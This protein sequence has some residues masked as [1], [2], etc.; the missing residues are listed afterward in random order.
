[1]FSA[2]QTMPSSTSTI[3]TTRRTIGTR[4]SSSLLWVR[5]AILA[6]TSAI[7]STT[8]HADQTTPVMRTR[9]AAFIRIA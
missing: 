2:I 1:M 7:Q 3:F 8:R 6:K 4:M 9:R 5:S